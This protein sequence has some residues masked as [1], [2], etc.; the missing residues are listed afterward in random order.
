MKLNP[1]NR[2]PS[3]LI[4]PSAVNYLYKIGLCL[5]NENKTDKKRGFINK[6]IIGFIIIFIAAVR[7]IILTSHENTYVFI[8]LGD[9]SYFAFNREL[10]IVHIYNF[11]CLNFALLTLS[12]QLI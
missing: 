8:Y 4:I 12:S 5:T 6:P 1:S 3:Y 10:T 7:Y 2:L 11:A 9:F